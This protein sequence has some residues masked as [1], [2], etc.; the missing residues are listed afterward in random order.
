ML[1]IKEIPT[2]IGYYIAG[3]V[4]GEGSFMVVFRPREDYKNKWKITPVFN[5]SQKDP[6]V[7]AL[8]KRYL[9]CGVLR[10]RK[11]GVWYYEVNNINSIRENVIPFFNRFGFL[12]ATKKNDFSKFKKIVEILTSSKKLTKEQLK[13][14]LKLRKKIKSKYTDEEILNS[15]E[16]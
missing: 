8:M 15:W 5:V 4:D 13:E 9:K 2:N 14:I 6:T 16:E 3:F 1:K 11:D 10:Q 12:S 7:L